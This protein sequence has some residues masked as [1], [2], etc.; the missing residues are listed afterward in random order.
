MAMNL[1][2]YGWNATIL[3]AAITPKFD[4]SLATEYRISLRL[5]VNGESSLSV[6]FYQGPFGSWM[7]R[8]IEEGSP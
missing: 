2:D 5:L 8:H 6:A 7:L 4:G 3:P 1:V